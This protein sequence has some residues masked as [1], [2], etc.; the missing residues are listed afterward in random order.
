[1]CQAALIQT[2]V[3]LLEPYLDMHEYAN[4]NKC[5]P[6]RLWCKAWLSLERRRYFGLYDR[7]MAELRKEDGKSFL[8]F[9]RIP[10]DMFD[11]ILEQVVPRTT[12]Q[13]TQ[14]R[15]PLDQD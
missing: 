7:L 9:M 12:K 14:Y 5:R 10:S 4:Q 6:R 3:N 2:Q 13:R 11:E 15:D 8:N 1:M